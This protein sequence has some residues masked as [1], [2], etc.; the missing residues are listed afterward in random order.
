[1]AMVAFEGSVASWKRGGK[2]EDWTGTSAVWPEQFRAR[3][4]SRA[5]TV[6]AGLLGTQHAGRLPASVIKPKRGIPR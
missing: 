3:V 5:P 1:M 6:C 2:Q 4:S